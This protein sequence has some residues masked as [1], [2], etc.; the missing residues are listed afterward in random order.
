MTRIQDCTDPPHPHP[1]NLLSIRPLDLLTKSYEVIKQGV[2]GVGWVCVIP[3]RGRPWLHSG[4]SL[5][6][7]LF[8]PTTSHRKYYTLLFSAACCL[9]FL[10]VNQWFNA[11]L[12]SKV[13]WREVGAPV[14]TWPVWLPPRCPSPPP[15]TPGITSA[16]FEKGQMGSALMGSPQILCFLTGTFWYSR[17]PT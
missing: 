13:E 11:P 6:N 1:R 8:C 16:R 5:A 3:A 17:E 4:C 15:P 9:L 2:A 7:R 14:G 12:I 10:E